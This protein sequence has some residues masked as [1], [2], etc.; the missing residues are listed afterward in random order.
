MYHIKDNN[1]TLCGKKL[2][3]LNKGEICI[4]MLFANRASLE[5]CCPMCKKTYLEQLKSFLNKTEENE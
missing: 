1:K 4:S 3:K 5:Q 2:K